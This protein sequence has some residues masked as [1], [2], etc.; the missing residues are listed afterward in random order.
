M[1]RTKKDHV[2]PYQLR[3]EIWNLIDDHEKN[4]INK[5][6]SSEAIFEKLYQ[7]APP[8]VSEN[9]FKRCINNIRGKHTLGQRP[10]KG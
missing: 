2:L 8:G 6:N 10:N 4:A 5:K 1:T 3:V 9:Q 7:H